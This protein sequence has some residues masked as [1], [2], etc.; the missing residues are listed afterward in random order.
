MAARIRDLPNRRRRVADVVPPSGNSKA[1]LS[2]PKTGTVEEQGLSRC[3]R[4]SPFAALCTKLEVGA[5]RALPVSLSVT[6]D[7]LR[8]IADNPCR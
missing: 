7:M 5:H 3:V 1:T 4:C 8:L 6:A 2:K